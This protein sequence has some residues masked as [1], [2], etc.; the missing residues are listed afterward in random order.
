MGNDTTEGSAEIPGGSHNRFQ[1]FI[2]INKIVGYVF[3]LCG[4]TSNA[5]G[6]VHAPVILHCEIWR[7]ALTCWNCKF[8]W[9]HI[10]QKF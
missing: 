7:T 9:L 3:I 4:V 5:V 8:L 6:S 1:N 2:V 10:D